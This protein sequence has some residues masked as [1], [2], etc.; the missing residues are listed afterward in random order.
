MS[1]RS[2]DTTVLIEASREQVWNVLSA[3]EAWPTWTLT[4]KSVRLLDGSPGTVGARYEVRQP[5]L[6]KAV[7]TVDRWSPHQS[8]LWSS[9]ASGVHTSADHVL[10]EDSPTRTNVTLSLEMRGALAPLVWLLA[11]GLVRRYVN[12][13]AASLKVAVEQQRRAS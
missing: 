5:R 6:A 11:G 12:T 13:E 8:F 1:A 7:F 4:M 10:V 9:K 2:Y 3:V